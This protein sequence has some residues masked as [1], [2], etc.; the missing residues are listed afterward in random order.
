MQLAIRPVGLTWA[1]C[2]QPTQW[3]GTYIQEN[4]DDYMASNYLA[5]NSNS[6][7]S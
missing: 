6:M 5:G 2:D 1:T 3:F 4:L 7:W